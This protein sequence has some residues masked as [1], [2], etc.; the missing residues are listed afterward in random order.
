MSSDIV[1]IVGGL[2]VAFSV[3]RAWAAFRAFL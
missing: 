3:I 1:A 2:L